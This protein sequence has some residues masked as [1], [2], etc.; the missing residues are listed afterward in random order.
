MC[1][2]YTISLYIKD[3]VIKLTASLYYYLH[4]FF[5]LPHAMSASSFLI[6]RL[7]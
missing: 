3:A 2:L 7:P 5:F 4:F 6:P 1:D